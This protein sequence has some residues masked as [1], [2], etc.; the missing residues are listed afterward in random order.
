M[1]TNPLG[2][3]SNVCELTNQCCEMATQNCCFDQ[4]PA[5]EPVRP[6]PR[7][8]TTYERKC[9]SEDAPNCVVTANRHCHDIKVLLGPIPRKA[10][11]DN[12]IGEIKLEISNLVRQ[13]PTSI[14]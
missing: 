5:P 9:D 11:M 7:C 13:S 10:L 3:S 14:G 12:V 8:F 6:Q 1:P 4:T 2:Y